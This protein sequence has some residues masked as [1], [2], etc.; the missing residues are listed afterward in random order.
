MQKVA[1]AAFGSAE[2]E[3]DHVE[4]RKGWKKTVRNDAATSVIEWCTVITLNETK[5]RARFEHGSRRSN[6]NYLKNVSSRLGDAQQA[7]DNQRFFLK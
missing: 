4:G 6:G 1:R 7:N 5:L 2:N 3:I